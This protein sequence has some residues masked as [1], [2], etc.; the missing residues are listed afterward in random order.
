MK[1]IAVADRQR[2]ARHLHHSDDRGGTDLHDLTRMENNPVCLAGGGGS[3]D[4]PLN[5]PSEFMERELAAF[6]KN[7]YLQALEC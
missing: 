2:S 4:T 3:N 1:M 7:D 6:V 5:T